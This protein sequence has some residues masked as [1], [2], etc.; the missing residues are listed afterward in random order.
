MPLI[1]VLAAALVLTQPERRSAQTAEGERAPERRRM[2]ETQIRARGISSIAVLEA[3]RRVPRHL[4]VPPSGQSFAYEDRPLPIGFNQ[5]ISQPYIVAYMSEALDVSPRHTV[6]E[7][8]TGSGYQAAVL[9]E[10]AGEVYSI[11]IVP[12]LA[13]R[14]RQTLASAGYRNVHVRNGDGYEGWPEHAPF[15]RIVVTAAPPEIPTV[16]VEQLALGG[17]MVVPVGRLSQA[18]TIV[19]RTARGVTKTETIPVRFVPMVPAR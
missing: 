7:I 18:M 13:D 1:L 17:I 12:E 10:L 19:T 9:A 4:F 16:L 14:A 6:L 3:M 8:G 5:T 15:D 2:V 11:E